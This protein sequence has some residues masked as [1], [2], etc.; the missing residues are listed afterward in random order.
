M[1]FNMATLTEVS[2]IARKGIKWGI[3]ILVIMSL[4]PGAI[5]LIQ[6]IYL[7]LNPPPPPPP[8]VRYGKLPKLK[9]PESPN[10][11]TPE[12]KLE[13][14][15]LGL[16]A[17]PSV[18]KVYLV[19]INKSRLLVLER[20]TEKAKSVGLTTD[21]IQLDERTY[22]FAH[23]KLPIDMVFDVITGSF[24][25]KYDWT[26]NKALGSIFGLPNKDGATSDA[27]SFL[28]KLGALPTDLTNGIGKVI[29][30]SATA[31]AMVPAPSFY[32][33]NF[34]RIDIFRA[35]KDEK[36]PGISQPVKMRF[37][38][39]GGDTAPVN[40][41]ISGLSGSSRVVQANYYYSQIFGDDYA[42]YP[43]KSIQS[44]WKELVEGGGFI[45]KRTSE[46]KVTVRW[47][48]IGY[49]ESNEQQDFLQPVFIFEG[50]GGFMA[51]VQAVDPSKIVN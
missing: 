33:S 16:P 36:V 34:A 26:T 9:F 38:T 15:S 24:S 47:I 10:F 31:S 12:Y 17:M 51:Y 45:A 42:T 22:R 40:V 4:I 18:S 48:S 8:T 5:G 6:K 21:P 13:T 49:F 7:A 44:A 41:I 46:S 35:D 11:A 43:L 50:D 28:E 37:V 32:E 30:L 23:P 29:Y 25:Y 27:K 1:N 39:V 20:M 2:V 14:V 19:G 3:I